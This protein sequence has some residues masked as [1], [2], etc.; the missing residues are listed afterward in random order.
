MNKKLILFV[1]VFGVILF[2]LARSWVPTGMILGGHDSGLAINASQF[3]NKRLL[4]WDETVNFGVDNSA[5]FGSLT[6]HGLDLILA[7]LG[8]TSF[9][10]N[11]LSFIFWIFLMFLSAV[12][13]SLELKKYF[14]KAITFILPIFLVMNFY[15]FQSVFILE[16]A[17]YGI[18]VE[19]L[20]ILTILFRLKRKQI[21]VFT[22]AFLISI[23]LVIFNG[24]SWLGIPLFGGLI[25]V[26]GTFLFAELVFSVKQRS[27]VNL[28]RILVTLFLSFA[29]LFALTTYSWLPYIGNFVKSDAQILSDQGSI[30]GNEAWLDNMSQG[31]SILNLIRFQGTPDWY[32]SSNQA[33]PEHQYAGLYIKNNFLIVV[34]FIFPV[35]ALFSLPSISKEK[36][37]KKKSIGV[38][39]ILLSFLSLIFVAG[40]HPPTGEIYKLLFT[41]IPGF[42]IFRSP[43]YKFGYAFML[44]WSV[45]I[46]ISLSYFLKR[47]SGA[48]LLVGIIIVNVFVIGYYSPMLSPSKLFHWKNDFSTVFRLPSY[49]DQYANWANMNTKDGRTL[50]LPPNND[51]WRSDG[52]NFGYWSTT[53]LLASASNVKVLSNDSLLNQAESTWVNAI[54]AAIK[55]GDEKNFN[56][57][58]DKLGV[59]YF[60]VREDVLSPG[61]WSAPED[62]SIY[63][64]ALKVFS[65]V[66]KLNKFGNWVVYSRA[67][68][69]LI[70]F[71]ALNNLTHVFSEDLDYMG[72][73]YQF[74]PAFTNKDSKDSVTVLKCDICK[75]LEAVDPNNQLRFSTS[76]VLPNSILY[77]LKQMRRNY[78]ASHLAGDENVRINY[79]LGEIFSLGGEFKAINLNPISDRFQAVVFQ[80]IKDDIDALN[81]LVISKK[82]SQTDYLLAA[83]I[84]KY[85][86][87]VEGLISQYFRSFPSASLSIQ[88]QLQ[89]L[90]WDIRSLNNHFS[91]VWDN[92]SGTVNRKSYPFTISRNGVYQI[93]IK[94]D[95]QL[96]GVQKADLLKEGSFLKQLSIGNDENW[97]V[98]GKINLEKGRYDLILDI[99]PSGNVLQSVT[100]NNFS[101]PYNGNISCVGGQIDKFS[102]GKKYLVN[103]SS[104][105]GLDLYFRENK[106]DLPS[107]FLPPN[108]RLSA[109]FLKMGNNDNYFY[110]PYST[111]KNSAIYV[112]GTKSNLNGIDNL[113][114]SEVRVPE[115]ILRSY[116][117]DVQSIPNITADKISPVK[118]IVNIPTGTG[119]FTLRFGERFDP[120][121]QARYLDNNQLISDHVMIDGYAN[122]WIIPQISS[123][124]IVIEYSPQNKFNLG[125]M[126]S[127]VSFCLLSLVFFA[128][129]VFKKN[130]VPKRK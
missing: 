105:G 58:A 24:G 47:F 83:N 11:T 108:N 78:S 13:L 123:R 68:I 1:I 43:Y 3:F 84:F 7:R 119:G 101:N 65:S 10:G 14:G 39:F 5:Y 62:F 16:R 26:V 79:Y 53:T 100:V 35:L 114:V 12:I 46:A 30:S 36:D 116:S 88:S 99:P 40:S 92:L 94:N 74:S 2:I 70:D 104:S 23:L 107:Y 17:K 66:T 118:Y 128:K 97:S 48:R 31:T 120:R 29:F 87:P 122:G 103:F 4:S 21:S 57:L 77:K 82:G 49:V 45:L 96:G 20:L 81:S 56:L 89:A 55:R 37:I 124:K 19:T 112:C 110:S 117:D 75:M 98:T 129:M 8:G 80:Q 73:L 121:W 41:R 85:T 93:L 69:N 63:E 52:Y 28:K 125:V 42:I 22:S 130:G 18:Y 95:M 32:A 61:K 115:V 113:T 76:T 6:M 9:A 33:N 60:L 71:T 54:Y 50:L 34:S 64:N 51:E 106:E 44:G 127:L 90:D 126:V 102:A 111:A 38:F 86:D 25:V 109:I 91:L 15:I 27:F 59:K 72:K 67:N